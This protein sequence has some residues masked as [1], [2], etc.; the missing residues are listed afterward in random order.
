MTKKCTVCKR[1]NEEVRRT[2]IREEGKE[3][4]EVIGMKK[5][6]ERDKIGKEGKEREQGSMRDEN[7]PR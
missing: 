1:E 3:N 6:R 7:K 5:G 2:K 4:K